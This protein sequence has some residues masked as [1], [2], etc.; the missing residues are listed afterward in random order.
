M[1]SLLTLTITLMSCYLIGSIPTAYIFGRIFKGIDIRKEGSGNVG[2]TNVYRVAGKLPGLLVL[3]LDVLK[4]YVC[5]TFVPASFGIPPPKLFFS[6]PFNL[7]EIAF[8]DVS[9]PPLYISLLFGLAAIL[10]HNWSVFLRFKGGKGIATSTGVLLALMPQVLYICLAVWVVIF[11][12]T[13]YVSL[14]SILASIALPIIILV[15]NM[16][17]KH[18]IFGIT[19]C[20]LSS[21]KHKSNIRRLL[22]GQE[23]RTF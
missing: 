20:I 3:L 19:L 8:F 9:P 7:G 5:T 1:P 15:L 2:A 12:L 10:G 16:D 11:V 21:Y 14:A 6:L 4:G 23:P 22:I 17:T 13:R 18:I